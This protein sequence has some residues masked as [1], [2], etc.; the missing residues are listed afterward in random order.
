MPDVFYVLVCV[1]ITAFVVLD[2]F[3]FG[4]GALLFLVARTPDER[5]RVHRAIG[6]FWDGNEVWL[7]AAAGLLFAAFPRA[8]AAAMSGFYLGMVLVIWLFIGRALAIELRHHVE[9]ALFAGLFDVLFCAAS[10]GLPLTLGIALGNLIRGVPLEEGGFALPFFA[11]LAGRGEKGLIDVFTLASGV[12]AVLATSLH[13]AAFLAWREDGPVGERAR[14]L[15]PRLV[16]AVAILLVVAGAATFVFA[17]PAAAALRSRPTAITFGA[18]APLLLGAARWLSGKGRARDAFLASAGFLATTLASIA[19]A[20]HPYL[21]RGIPEALS[22]GTDS[23]AGST[24]LHA[25]LAWFAI[26]FPLACTYVGVIFR[27]ERRGGA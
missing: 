13:G 15:V 27:Y 21:V 8:L 3:D 20:Q 16:V 12:V 2:G 7:L 1:M 23:H 19:A 17:G 5:R 6:P 18:L 26:G 4:A 9:D 11:D 24:S 14:A 10:L 25:A 22:I